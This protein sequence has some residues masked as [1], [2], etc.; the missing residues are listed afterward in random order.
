MTVDL[1]KRKPPREDLKE[2]FCKSKMLNKYRTPTT[3]HRNLLY[4]VFVFC[5][6]RAICNK[7]FEVN[8]FYPVKQQTKYFHFN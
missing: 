1:L 6:H 4:S 5:E 2:V 3:E 7:G 8:A